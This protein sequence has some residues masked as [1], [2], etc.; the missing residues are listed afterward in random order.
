MFTKFVNII[1]YIYSRLS[2]STLYIYLKNE[3]NSVKK[4]LFS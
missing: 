3:Y 2:L 4:V 1:R